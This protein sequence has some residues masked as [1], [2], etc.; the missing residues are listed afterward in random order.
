MTVETVERNCN[1]LFAFFNEEKAL[2]FSGGNVATPKY[3][4]DTYSRILDY[5]GA[6]RSGL[7]TLYL[8]MAD[9]MEMEEWLSSFS[10]EFIY[11]HKAENKTI[12]NGGQIIPIIRPATLGF[13]YSGYQ[14]HIEC[15]YI[16]NNVI[17]NKLKEVLIAFMA[18]GCPNTKEKTWLKWFNDDFLTGNY[19]K[20]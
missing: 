11:N 7:S 15:D 16:Q 14:W 12:D 1:R 13:L 9:Y 5:H 18:A 20:P 8:P 19:Y 17:E 10:V 3:L 4:L 2:T 6:P